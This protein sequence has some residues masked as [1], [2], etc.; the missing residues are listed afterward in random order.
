MV[1]LTNKKTALIFPDIHLDPLD[2]SKMFVYHHRY[3]YLFTMNTC[4]AMQDEE[5]SEVC[6][7]MFSF[8]R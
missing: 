1:V 2:S 5:I 4:L 3:M 7:C 6:L 8:C